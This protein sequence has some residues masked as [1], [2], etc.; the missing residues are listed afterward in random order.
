MAS[1]ADI[2]FS[3]GTEA[4][5]RDLS[6]WWRNHYKG[7]AETVT[8]IVPR[9]QSLLGELSAMSLTPEAA[10]FWKRR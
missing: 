9:L 2:A 3:Y 4:G 7:N 1:E 6:C 10:E 5:M 8:S